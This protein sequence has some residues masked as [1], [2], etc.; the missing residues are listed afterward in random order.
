MSDQSTN[1]SLLP[2]LGL[3]APLLQLVVY[4]PCPGPDGSPQAQPADYL[5]VIAAHQRMHAD[6]EALDRGGMP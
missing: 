5:A 3:A 1:N 4:S 6:I 2:S